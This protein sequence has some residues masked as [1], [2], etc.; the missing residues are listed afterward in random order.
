MSWKLY[1]HRNNQKIRYWARE[2]SQTSNGRNF[3]NVTYIS[4][5]EIRTPY[6]VSPKEET[7]P[8]EQSVPSGTMPARGFEEHYEPA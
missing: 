8:I 2:V 7:L 4:G 1:E 6:R 3:E 5:Y